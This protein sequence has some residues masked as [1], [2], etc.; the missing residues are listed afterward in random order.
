L[1]IHEGTIVFRPVLGALLCTATLA[2]PGPGIDQ[3]EAVRIALGNNLDL[4]MAA[5]DLEAA[6]GRVAD[7][8]VVLRD[9][10]EL[11]A[12]FAERSS[13][14]GDF[15]DR[16]FSLSQKFEVAGQRR[17]RVS[18]AE[19][20]LAGLEAE[21][22]HL[23]LRIAGEVRVA[24]LDAVLARKSASFARES[25][26]LAEEMLDLVTQRRDAG[27]ATDLEVN[28]AVIE[29]ARARRAVSAAELRG[30]ESLAELKRV[31]AIPESEPLKITGE[32][33]TPGKLDVPLDTLVERALAA[34]GDLLALRRAG[35]AREAEVRLAR[36]KRLPD[37]G[38]SATY[39]REEGTDDIH[40]VG[41]AVSLPVFN[42]GKGKIA[43]ARARSSRAGL[44][45]ER[46]RL[47]IERQVAEAYRRYVAAY[48]YVGIY[49]REILDRVTDNLELLRLSLE[50]G[51]IGPVEL[52]PVRR[53]LTEVRR[54]YLESLGE[55]H[56]ARAAL[57]IAVGGNLP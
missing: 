14:D 4:R 41:V 57:E 31:L 50:A 20:E 10:P 51:K 29:N 28:L 24:F 43:E 19:S 39:E 44:E 30:R 23:R 54:E 1:D 21:V 33:E 34:R 26:R 16:G 25:S 8:R 18:A 7:A 9:N 35:E 38:L 55:L 40:G 53:D 15:N 2:S 48:E 46:G 42:R 11:E 22:E 45:L 12:E 52:I 36:T 27:D 17:H 3:D 49:D 56:R 47:E 5:A 37:L 6:R 13:P 32:I